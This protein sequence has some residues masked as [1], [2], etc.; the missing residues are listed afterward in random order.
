MKS[1]KR[2]QLLFGAAAFLC[3]IMI[4]CL[5]GRPADLSDNDSGFFTQIAVRVLYPGYRGWDRARQMAILSATDKVVRKSAHFGEYFILCVLYYKTLSI[6]VRKAL[7][8]SAALAVL[9][10]VS[11]ELHQYFVPGRAAMAADVLIDSSGVLL[12]VLVILIIRRHRPA[13]SSD[14]K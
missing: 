13:I 5:S 9:Y 4:F 10:A 2:R 6:S 11:D 8:A 1:E 14:R 7:A 3:M 12:A